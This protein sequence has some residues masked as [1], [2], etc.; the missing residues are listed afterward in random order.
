MISNSIIFLG[1]TKFSEQILISLIENKYD[2]K[3][4]F[5]IPEKFRISYSK[6]KVINTNFADL[7]KL[8]KRFSIPLKYSIFCEAFG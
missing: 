7:S 1:S 4:I 8:A 3:A 5:S 6:E 2:I